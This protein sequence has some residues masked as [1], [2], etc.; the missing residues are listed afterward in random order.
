LNGNPRRSKLAEVPL[1][2]H[3]LAIRRMMLSLLAMVLVALTGALFYFLL[4]R[5][6]WS[7]G[8]CA[9]MA[10]ITISTVGF[11]E[12]NQ[13]EG[14]PGARAVTIA[15]I[16]G[17]LGVIAYFQA[18]LTSILVEGS[19]GQVF[20]RNR[21]R[22][23]IIAQEGHVV[24]AGA[25]STGRHVIEELVKT[26]RP[27]VVIERD[28]EHAERISEEL[29]GGNMLV[30]HGDATMD[31][32]LLQ[33][34]VDRA[35]GVVAALTHD[36]DNLFVTLSARGL[37]PTARIVAKVVEDETTPKMLKAGANRVVSPA[38]IGGM[39]MVSELVRPDVTEFLDLM[40][41][42]KDRALRF[43]EVVIRAGSV[44][45][46]VA[47]KDSSIR[48]DTRALIVAMR[49]EDGVFSYNPEPTIVMREG[50]T[51]VAIG[52][53]DNIRKLRALAGEPSPVSR[54]M[55]AS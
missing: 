45:I 46:D 31:H 41:R 6:R 33:A 54:L 26:E 23:K 22:K 42:D 50:W 20:R 18:N 40:V 7:F 55:G 52:E 53:P 25:G 14:V 9:Y 5:G 29:M 49:G 28:R 47:L 10:I 38:M 44:L 30:V 36:K 4:G 3:D 13:M 19:V 21:M 35:S 48:R 8:E 2:K 24:V 37:N 11:G 34:G 1:A 51:L 15:L 12:L 39:R 27:F 16:I 17:G 32:V 43:E